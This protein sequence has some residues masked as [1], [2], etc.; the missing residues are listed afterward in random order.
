MTAK[1]SISIV[2]PVYNE[3]DQIKDCLDSIARQT[4]APD[5]V[6]VVDNNCT[7][8]T[9][10]I[11]KRYQFV[12]VI[13]EKNQGRGFARSAG[14]E[15]VNSDIIGR[16]DA[17]S[18]IESNWVETVLKSFENDQELMGLTGIGRTSFLPGFQRIKTTFFSHSYYWY[19]RAGFQTI[20]MW[21]A[22]MAIRRSAWAKISD[23][24]CNDDNLVHE[25]QDVSLWLAG[26]GGKIVQNNSLRIT[27]NGADYMNIK[28]TLHYR[29]LYVSTKKIHRDNGN[30]GRARR[31]NHNIV[32]HIAGVFGVYVLGG[33]ILLLSAV[34]FVIRMP[35][36]LFK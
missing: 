15:S 33:L 4:V 29:A 23:K 3:E 16:I 12:R 21:G 35:F 9:I 24:V 18:R 11:A 6:I 34:L 13:S 26:S 25:D 31:S 27:A 28:K 32:T 14:F 36:K 2:I 1:L 7:D 20:T 30:L 22:T 17:D 5:E 19:V 8:K 10:E